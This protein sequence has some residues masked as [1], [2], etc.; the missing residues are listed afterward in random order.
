MLVSINKNLL[1]VAITLCS[2]NYNSFHR[3][4]HF[5]SQTPFGHHS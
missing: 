5:V 1:Y 4:L 2:P 3:E